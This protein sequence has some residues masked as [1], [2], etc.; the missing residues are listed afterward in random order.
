MTDPR[1][2]EAVL[3]EERQLHARVVD[4]DELALMELFDRTACVVHCGA[5][6]ITD[7]P[8]EA[9]DVVE[10][11]FVEYWR[12]PQGFDPACGPL[13]LQMVRRLV[14]RSRAPLAEAS[15]AGGAYGTA[16]ATPIRF[17]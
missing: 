13:S 15:S 11:L 5:M 6:S 10:A 3:D 4:R 17:S 12:S 16:L 7:T 1:R 14:R 9:A 8:A 2:I